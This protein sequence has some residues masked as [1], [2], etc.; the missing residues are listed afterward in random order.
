[1][2]SDDK[3]LNIAEAKEEIKN[4]MK[5]Y[6]AKNEYGEYLIPI[7]RQRPVFLMGPPG[8]GKTAIIKQI[9]EELDVGFNPYSMTHHTRQSALGLPYIVQKEYNGKTY[10]VSEYTMSEIISETYEL[11]KETGKKEGILFLD[12][13]NC[14]SETLSPVMLQLLQQKRFGEHKVPD[15]WI[16]VAAGNPPEFNNSVHQFDVVTWDRLKKIEIKYDFEVW[17]KYAVNTGVH[18]AII[19]YLEVKVPNCYKIESTSE[20]QTYVTARGWDDLSS[21]VRTYEM[22]QIP[23]TTQLV[24]QY[25]TNYKIASDFAN[26]YDMYSKY[27]SDYQIDRILEG[28]FD[29]S[30]RARALRAKFDE[31]IALLSLLADAIQVKAR[32]S[33]I[34]QMAAKETQRVLIEIKD[35]AAKN[36]NGET[37]IVLEHFD[38]ALANKQRTLD[39]GISAGSMSRRDISRMRA[40]ISMLGDLRT[41]CLKADDASKAMSI[42]R[43]K[44]N[45]DVKSL[46]AKAK[47]IGAELDNELNFIKEVYGQ[48]NEMLIFMTTLTMSWEIAKFV[49]DNGS[50]A[51][52]EN[53]KE[54]LVTDRAPEIEKMI[55]E[56]TLTDDDLLDDDD[57]SDKK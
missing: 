34:D 56:L 4:T 55:K 36:P 10:Q 28:T 17:K 25:L 41:R 53:D 52:H 27:K 46:R 1:M 16:I 44:F 24:V 33:V 3:K 47:K 22:L 35:I 50:E 51:Y 21:M 42:I 49:A 8:L 2:T 57:N 43:E 45:S 14:V 29:D 39:V 12:E 9:A 48:G 20:G 7:E 30:I 31:R 54:M 19:S 38:E 11:I 15:G 18:P 40:V 32:K 23:V 13:L 37:T 5:A 6:F 26:Y